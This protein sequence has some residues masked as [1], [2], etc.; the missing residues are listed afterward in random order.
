M[1][2]E[3]P[4]EQISRSSRLDFSPLYF[5]SY[6]LSQ[7]LSE[8]G[9][10]RASTSLNMAATTETAPKKEEVDGLITY[11]DDDEHESKERVIQKYF[12]QEWK[13]VKSILDDIVSNGCVS[14]ISAVHKIRSIVIFS[15]TLFPFCVMIAYRIGGLEIFSDLVVV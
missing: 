13:L 1:D 14:D 11:D 9:G 4:T 2:A 6:I 5:S 15:G 7:K 8:A 10:N 12:L 3:I